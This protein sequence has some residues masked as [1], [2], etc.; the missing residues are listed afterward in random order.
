MIR[1][2]IFA[3]D[4]GAGSTSVGLL[5]LRVAG[6]SLFVKH[7]WENPHVEVVA[8]YMIIFAILLFTG[9][10]RFSVDGRLQG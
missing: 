5:V 10:G 2:V 8:L 9:P 1:K 7:G 3:S 6:L 4:T